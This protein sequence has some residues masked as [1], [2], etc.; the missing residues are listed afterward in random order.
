LAFFAA[1]PEIAA[2]LVG[3]SLLE[4]FEQILSAAQSLP[5]VPLDFTPFACF[6]EQMVNPSLWQ[7]QRPPVSQQPSQA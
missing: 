2:A 6:D 7:V 3:V 4:E 1:I 5:F